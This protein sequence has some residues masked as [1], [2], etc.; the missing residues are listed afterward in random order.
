MEE[1]VTTSGT[2]LGDGSKL[3]KRFIRWMEDNR[4][5]ILTVFGL[6]LSF[7]FDIVMQVKNIRCRILR[8]RNVSCESN[9]SVKSM[10]QK[11]V[12]FQRYETGSN[13]LFLH[14]LKNTMKE[15]KRYKQKSEN[16]MTFLWIK[17]RNLL[18]VLQGQIGCHFPQRFSTKRRAIKYRSLYMIYCPW[19]KRI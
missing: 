10:L 8:I 5:L 12:Y 9:R 17:K 4:G 13:E 7:L 11:S 19:M 15:Y 3:R 1:N 16:G 14:L 2:V 6:P 18:C